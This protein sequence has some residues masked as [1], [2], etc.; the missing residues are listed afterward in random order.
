MN[1]YLVFSFNFKQKKCLI[2]DFFQ[3]DS[4]GVPSNGGDAPIQPRRLPLFIA[5]IAGMC[6]Q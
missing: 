5:T 3:R 2:I 1:N 6:S 4:M